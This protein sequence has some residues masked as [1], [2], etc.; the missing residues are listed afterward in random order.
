VPL[1][2]TSRRETRP[3][4]EL[5]DLVGAANVLTDPST[6]ERYRVDWTRRFGGRAAT[7][8][9]P[10]STEEVAAVVGWCA[11]RRVPIVPQGGNTGLAGGSVPG[12]DG[13]VI[14]GTERLVACG[15]V[16]TALGQVTVGAGVTPT[17]LAERLAGSGW[18]F[19]VDLGA[20]DSATIGGMVATNAGGMRVFRFG[21]MRSQLL[22]LEY[23]TAGGDV[24]SRLAGL[25][26][27]NTGYDLA[28]LLCGSEGTLGVVT[29][30]RLRLVPDVAAA[31]TALLGFGD[32]AAAR[33]A[34]WS[35]RRSVDAVEVLEYVSGA[36]VE[37]VADV[38]GAT[39][40]IAAPHVLLVEAAGAVDPT[41]DLAAGVDRLDGVLG[42]AVAADPGRRAELWRFRDD[43]TT[44]LATL[45]PV[46]KYDVSVP[47]AEV[48]AFRA[49]A[50]HAVATLAPTATTWWFG[51]VCDDN[52]HLNVTGV[53]DAPDDHLD[54]AVFEAVAAHGG[55]IS[56]E[57]GIGRAKAA[58]LGLSRT[59]AELAQ[60]RA[61]KAAFDPLG[62]LNP[63]VLL[64]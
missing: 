49:V 46:R 14:L 4:T 50:D 5:A 47:S 29:A 52:L 39:P 13:A 34:A 20:R 28:G 36:C 58:Y 44:S 11:D 2:G 41:D 31:T 37:L 43:V 45:G 10:A 40:P 35:L 15:P 17:V 54:A 24:V 6:T 60:F 51:H 42:V 1:D 63:G 8:V 62:I 26:K 18:R 19:A 16:D 7:V 27:D 3:V 53:D 38:T 56:A 57:H 32:A 9:R 55:S 23:V 59:A 22:G 64:A 25:R 30:A 33:D 21:P 48:D 61:V 12:S